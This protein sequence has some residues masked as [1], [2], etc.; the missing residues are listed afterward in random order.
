MYL[1]SF[2]TG[3]AR[4]RAERGGDGGDGVVVDAPEKPIASWRS[5]CLQVLRCTCLTSVE[6]IDVGSSKAEYVVA[7]AAMLDLPLRPI[8]SRSTRAT[9]PGVDGGRC[10]PRRNVLV[11]PG[12]RPLCPVTPF[13]YMK[14]THEVLV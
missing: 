14:Y 9:G 12:V 5:L 11:S 8:R 2:C 7:T 4:V 6:Y 1:E 10:M 13:L 3:H